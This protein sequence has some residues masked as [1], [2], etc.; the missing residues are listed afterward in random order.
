MF[1][2]YFSKVLLK[3]NWFSNFLIPPTIL[4]VI[5]LSFHMIL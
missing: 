1:V 5:L 3:M 4:F 2:R